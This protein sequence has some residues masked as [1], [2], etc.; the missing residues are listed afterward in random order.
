MSVGEVSSTGSS[1]GLVGFDS[2]RGVQ[3]RLS[4]SVCRVGSGSGDSC[5]GGAYS[6]LGKTSLVAAEREGPKETRETSEQDA[7]L[8]PSG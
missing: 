2:S 7:G 5:W 1:S 4:K 6:E 8:R 3:G